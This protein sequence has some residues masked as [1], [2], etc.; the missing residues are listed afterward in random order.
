MRAVYEMQA[1]PGTEVCNALELAVISF[2]I[3]GY[4]ITVMNFFNRTIGVVRWK[5]IHISD[6]EWTNIGICLTD[7]DCADNESFSN[8][9]FETKLK[10]QAMMEEIKEKYGYYQ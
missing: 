3:E 8:W 1:P 2:G 4:S 7:I 9:K 6:E 10:L 5:T